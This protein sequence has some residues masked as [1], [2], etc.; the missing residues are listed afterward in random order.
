MKDA[1]EVIVKYLAG[2]LLEIRLLIL[3]RSHVLGHRKNIRNVLKALKDHGE[4]PKQIHIISVNR[5]PIAE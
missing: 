1:F 3:T 5:I 2:S 4:R